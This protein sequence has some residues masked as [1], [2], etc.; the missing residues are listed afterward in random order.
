MT[1]LAKPGPASLIFG[2]LLLLGTIGALALA[3][4]R[5][6]RRQ[7]AERRD[8]QAAFRD[9]LRA[10]LA[11]QRSASE[12]LARATDLDS[13]SFWTVLES[14]TLEAPLTAR[15]ARALSRCPQIDDERRALRDDSP[16]RR[17]LA[18]RR[19]G[20]VRTRRTRRALRRALVRGPEL[21]TQSAAF[22]LARQR[23]G[24]ALR[25]LLRH[26]GALSHRTPRAR[27]ALL[28]AFG[29]GAHPLLLTALQEGVADTALERA[30]IEVLGA[31]G[32]TAAAAAIAARLARAEP[33]LRVAAARALGLLWAAPRVAE[34]CAALRD[35]EW[36]VRAQ[37]ARALGRL[38][39]PQAVPA[40]GALL[41]D[42]A[43]WVRRHAAYALAA[44]GVVGRAELERVRAAS[45]DRYA[46]EM[47]EEALRAG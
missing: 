8:D 19:L 3:T 28:R 43:W 29:R 46:R 17:D 18:A 32:C 10:F 37:A 24:G 30:L 13:S 36:P 11:R 22:A 23:D 9:E 15:L 5:A 41:E 35:P 12:L 44:L 42:R 33:E 4:W 26:P 25:W 38:A 27:L 21:V 1:P 31:G 34:L 20:L 40:L 6:A 2:P 47:A 14:R 45:A 7:R 16:W 39:Q